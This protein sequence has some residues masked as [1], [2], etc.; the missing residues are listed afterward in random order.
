MTRSCFTSSDQ[1]HLVFP[2]DHAAGAL[3]AVME[4]EKNLEEVEEDAVGGCGLEEGAVVGIAVPLDEGDQQ[5][6]EGDVED[7]DIEH[8]H[9]KVDA[10]PR[11]HSGKGV[12]AF[13]EGMDGRAE[14][15]CGGMRD[16]I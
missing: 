5:C 13:H 9:D 12:C 15:G 7:G 8:V 4:R 2:V 16:G 3:L 11:H 1:D 10:V 6:W 14:E